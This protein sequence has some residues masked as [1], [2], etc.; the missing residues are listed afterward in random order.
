MSRK[1]SFSTGAQSDLVRKGEEVAPSFWGPSTSVTSLS[2]FLS[3][4]PLRGTLLPFRMLLSGEV[5]ALF[6]GPSIELLPTAP[7][8]WQGFPSSEGYLKSKSN[9][10]SSFWHAKRISTSLD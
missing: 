4:Y 3:S 9:G 1:G 7:T 5:K 6:C 2:N 8:C 10:D